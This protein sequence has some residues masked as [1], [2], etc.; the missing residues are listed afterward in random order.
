MQHYREDPI[1]LKPGS[2]RHQSA[3]PAQRREAGEKGEKSLL[4]VQ[5]RRSLKTGSIRTERSNVETCTP[6]WT[7]NNRKNRRKKGREEKR[8]NIL[9]NLKRRKKRNGGEGNFRK[10]SS[11]RAFQEK[12]EISTNQPK[13]E[14][15]GRD[16]QSSGVGEMNVG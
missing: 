14:G 7:G 9:T 6:L 4:L 11:R 16:A 2:R 15:K 12:K 3:V 1:V 8:A 10:K 5:G 13:D